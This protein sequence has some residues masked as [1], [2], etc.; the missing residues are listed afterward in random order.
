[1]NSQLCSQGW[2]SLHVTYS[3]T[4]SLEA[5]IRGALPCWRRGSGVTVNHYFPRGLP[6]PAQLFSKARGEAD[7]CFLSLGNSKGKNTSSYIQCISFTHRLYCGS[8]V[9]CLFVLFFCLA[10][11]DEFSQTNCLKPT[12]HCFTQRGLV[13]S[14]YVSSNTRN[15]PPN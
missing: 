8:I 2:V 6:L 11:R 15:K 3:L 9:R 5:T 4:V 10:R 14:K 1:M 12:S 13:R 7:D